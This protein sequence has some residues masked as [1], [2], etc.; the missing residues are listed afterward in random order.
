MIWMAL[1]SPSGLM[2]GTRKQVRPLVRVGERQER[3]AH[4]RRAEPFVADEPVIGARAAGA[5]RKSARRVGAHVGAALLLGH[6]HA[7]R[8]PAL[9]G[10]R[11]QRRIVNAVDDFRRPRRRNIRLMPKRR[12]A[13]IGH[14]DRAHG[15]RLGLAESASIAAC[16]TCLPRPLLTPA[17]AVNAMLHR[18]RHQPM[19]GR[20]KLHLVDAPAEA[21]EGLKLGQIAIGVLAPLHRLFRAGRR[22]QRRQRLLDPFAAVK[23]RRIAKRGPPH[24][25]PPR[26]WR[27]NVCDLMRFKLGLRSVGG[28]WRS[29][30]AGE[31]GTE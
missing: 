25:V 8:D 16:A 14:A 5:Q 17:D 2:R 9:L 13:G 18:K 30:A 20:V 1:R 23:P 12:D 19:I 6:R 15:P 7:E 22:A 4:G 24:K 11:P 3:V 21:V 31:G 27:R 10:D 28:H 26:E 29:L